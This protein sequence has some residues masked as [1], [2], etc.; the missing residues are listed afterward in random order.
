VK[1]HDV[2]GR[3]DVPNRVCSECCEASP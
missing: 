3:R 2:H 1:V